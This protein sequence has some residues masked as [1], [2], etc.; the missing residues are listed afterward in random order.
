M[1]ISIRTKILAINILITAVLLLFIGFSYERSRAN[2]RVFEDLIK[3]SA[4][5][6]TLRDIEVEI[7]NI[8]QYLTDASLTGDS[9]V[10]SNEAAA[11]RRRIGEKLS[12]LKKQEPEFGSAIEAVS[13]S[14]DQFWKSGVDMQKAYGLSRAEGNRSMANF[15]GM[16]DQMLLSLES[17]SEPLRTKRNNAI[18]LYFG[19]LTATNIILVVGGGVLAVFIILS[20]IFLS[21]IISR[22]VRAAT[23]S[24]E[25]LVSS[26]GNLSFSLELKNRDE[27]GDMASQFN[28]F[29]GKIKEMM[30]AI[31]EIVNKNNKLGAH[32]SDASKQTAKSVSGIV[33][34]ISGIRSNSE[35][36][37]RSIQ[38]ASAAIE[39]IRQSISSLNNQVEQQFSAIEQSSSATEEIMASVTNVATIAKNRLASMDSIVA[40][41][42]KGGEKVEFTSEIIQEIQKNAD[43]MLDMIDIINNIS[44]QT[45]L[46]AMNASIEAAHAGDAGRGFSVVADEI[47]KLAEDTGEHAGRIGESLKSTTEK[48]AEATKAGEESEEAL[49]VINNEVGLFSNALREVSS[50]MNELSV[51]SNEIL[52]SVETLMDTSGIVRDA[53]KEMDLGASD[54]L[55]SILEIKEI[56]A[57]SL[58][59][60]AEVSIQTEHLNSVSLQ[61]ASFGNQNKYNNTLLSNELSQ[62]ETGFVADQDTE[63]QV[64][65]DWSDLLSVGIDKMDSEHK[66]LFVR[67]N[68]LLKALISRSGDYNIAEL[69]GFINEYIDFHFRDEEKMLES[70]N[71]PHLDAH[72]KL[73]KIYEDEFDQI[74]KK[75]RSGA[76]DASLLIEIQDKVVN[77]LL[78]HIAK[79]DKKYGEYIAEN[80]LNPKP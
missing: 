53:S 6:N 46:L 75:L 32:L 52:H 42:Q 35:S 40:L 16:A 49:N 24:L 21:L 57:Q 28:L 55:T 59:R 54:S 17:L 20:G 2:S 1:K 44:S 77:W 70:V 15:D 26:K 41:I 22:P 12:E 64:G 66:E 56:S 36:L 29:L 62:L 31:S 76:F 39:E 30:I 71:F 3:V 45:N 72:K 18:T 25:D 68:S 8:W 4:D 78:D 67:I 11:S 60:I 79:V 19:K 47:R 13:K 69:V 50:S 74:E 5:Y 73:H 43:D 38:Q 63:V 27:I 48:I 65:I 14:L 23:S 61:V 9:A 10:I 7:I 80:G 37:D 58:Q 33:E 34:S 51:A